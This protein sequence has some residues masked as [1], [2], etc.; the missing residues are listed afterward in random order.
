MSLTRRVA[1]LPLLAAAGAALAGCA[2]RPAGSADTTLQPAD[3]GAAQVSTKAEP[4]DLVVYGRVWT[5][6]SARPWASALAISG[7]RIV[8][9]GDSAEVAAL[10]GTGT[11]VLANGGGLVAPGFNDGHVHFHDGGMQLAR[12]DLRDAKTPAEFVARL[13]ARAA[14]LQP[15]EWILGGNWDHENWPGAPLPTRRWMDS[16]TPDNPVFVDRLDGHMGVANSK[17]LELA[18]VTRTTKD[19]EGGTI[20][21]D[22]GGD[23]TGVLK[24][25]AM[26]L[27]YAVLPAPTPAQSDSAVARATRWAASKGVTGVSAVSAS[28]AEVAAL[29]RAHAAGRLDT[30]VSVYVPIEVWR[31]MADTLRARGPGDDMLRVAG[32]KGYVDGSLGSGT[33]LFDEPYEDDP[34][35]RGLTV[36][37]V[38]SLRKWIGG[39]DSAG[40]QV[41]VHAIGEKANTIL[42]DIYDSVATAHGPRD[43]R[44]RVEHAQHLDPADVPR[45]AKQGVI[46]SMQPYH[47]I[48]DGRWA[49]KRLGDRVRNSYVFRGL[50]DT[51][52]QVAFGSDWSVAPIDPI[53]GIYAA[54]TRRTLD[55]KNPGGW[56]PE[57]KLTL[58]E[59]LRAYTAG[60]AFAAYAETKRGVLRPG[61]LA[62]LVLLDRNLFEIAP[63]TIRDAEVRATVVNGR[64]VYRAASPR[65]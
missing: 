2:G 5:G 21:R 39:A 23:P 33:A 46:A 19:V 22:A 49:H 18:K 65:I 56:L 25:A 28:W 60:N 6:D 32:V 20:V 51:K 1:S 59:A 10:V 7:D 24:D 15:G 35:T 31:P 27:I 37:P 42:L 57:Q 53:L 3:T 29:R 47:A 13:K 41:V 17:A 43:R 38:D 64:V 12:V 55:D 54:V 45:F 61:M 58:D 63:E 14:T 30:R 40:L 52:A 9:V 8:A 36:T 44:F 48:D 34:N 26:G 11:E 4:A 50:L 16:V 62:D